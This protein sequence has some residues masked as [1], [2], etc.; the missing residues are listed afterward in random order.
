KLAEDSNSIFANEIKN[1]IQ[2]LELSKRN[3][4]YQA[5][6]EAKYQTQTKLLDAQSNI[7]ST[8][9]SIAQQLQFPWTVQV[10]YAEQLAQL[11]EI[12]LQNAKERYALEVKT[13]KETGVGAQ[14][15]LDAQKLV[16]SAATEYASKLDYTRKTLFDIIK[17]EVLTVGGTRTGLVSGTIAEGAIKGP[18]WYQGAIAGSTE[19]R[20]MGLQW[21]QVMHRQFGTEAGQANVFQNLMAEMSSDLK[22]LNLTAVD[23]IGST[24][25]TSERHLENIANA[26]TDGGFMDTLFGKFFKE[27][28][29]AKSSTPTTSV[30]TSTPTTSV[31]TSTPTTSVPTSTDKYIPPHYTQEEA[32][33]LREQYSK[34]GKGFEGK[35][36]RISRAMSAVHGMQRAGGNLGELLIKGFSRDSENIISESREASKEHTVANKVGSAAGS[37]AVGG[38]SS[39]GLGTATS[40]GG[41]VSHGIVT[42]GTTRF[43]GEAGRQLSSD[44][45]LNMGRLGRETFEGGLWGGIGGGLSYKIPQIWREFILKKSNAETVT[46]LLPKFEQYSKAVSEAGGGNASVTEFLQSNWPKDVPLPPIRT[47]SDWHNLV[48]AIQ[49][50]ENFQLQYNPEY[51]DL[52]KQ[53]LR[54]PPSFHEGGMYRAPTLGGEGLALLKDREIILP[55]E[56]IGRTSST[57]DLTGAKIIVQL[58]TDGKDALEGT[59]VKVTKKQFV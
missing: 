38:A 3:L 37:I 10:S 2:Q 9:Q 53:G 48:K 43:I 8:M 22:V 49:T 34:E 21:Q 55:P 4:E 50:Q 27:E 13:Y 40:I 57:V 11:A 20:P 18:S 14:K 16:T 58:G 51:A 59:I 29:I 54:P 46:N 17:E 45:E 36:R 1:R 23:S 26:F 31:P 5:N 44:E 56:K 24:L 42:G 25:T 7:Y 41:A 32:N 47:T 52:V 33:I 30:P 6:I 15:V 19:G 35:G 28:D 39:A 12:Q